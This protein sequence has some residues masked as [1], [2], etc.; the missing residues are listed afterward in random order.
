MQ[1]PVRDPAPANAVRSALAFVLLWVAGAVACRFV[2]VW[3]GVGGAAILAGSLTW[4]LHRK[5]LTPLLRIEPRGILAGLAAGVAMTAATYALYPL[6]VTIAPAVASSTSELYLLFNGGWAP[7]RLGLLPLVILG[8]ELVWRGL[9][10]TVVERRAGRVSGALIAAAVYAAA[11]LPAATPLLALVALCCGLYWGALRAAT[12]SLA[13]PLI[14]H[15][16][17]D[18]CVMV[19]FPL[20]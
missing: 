9:V 8:E 5:A 4:A 3:G 2:G 11:H 20:I 13:A 10:Q 19:L 12:G 14:A 6:F 17:W 18:L 7:L 15:L 16:V 1:N